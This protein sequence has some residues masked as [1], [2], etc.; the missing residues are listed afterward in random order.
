MVAKSAVQHLARQQFDQRLTAIREITQLLESPRGGW[1]S[2]LRRA[3]GMTQAHLATRML[4]SRQAISQLEKREA[5]GAVTLKALEQA[6]E[7]LGGRLVYAIVPESGLA[8]TLERQALLV[9]SQMTG[10]VRHTMRLEDQE[11]T[12]DLDRRTKQLAQELLSSP[13]RLWSLPDGR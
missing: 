4:V 8:E 7:A 13:S 2:S 11:P 12:S 1:I 9:A 3:L 6:A 10:S 5:D